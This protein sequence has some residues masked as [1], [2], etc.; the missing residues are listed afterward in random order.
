M[1]QYLKKFLRHL[2]LLK[3]SQQSIV[4]WKHGN[5][6]KTSPQPSNQRQSKPDFFQSQSQREPNMF[7]TL[8]KSTT[9]Y[10]WLIKSIYWKLVFIAL[11]TTSDKLTILTV[12]WQ[13]EVWVLRTKME[14]F[15]RK[16]TSS[17][18]VTLKT[19]SSILWVKNHFTVWIDLM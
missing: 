9:L 12:F 1:F 6:W 3:A 8:V 5:K 16:R 14:W 18:L 4:D 17:M 13:F 2:V 7:V 15:E 19:S 11:F 10:S